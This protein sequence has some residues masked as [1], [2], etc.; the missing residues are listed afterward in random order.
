MNLLKK[1]FTRKEEPPIRFIEGTRTEHVMTCVNILTGYVHYVPSYFREG[2]MRR[3]MACEEVG[4][5]F[6]I[7]WVANHLRNYIEGCPIYKPQNFNAEIHGKCPEFI[8]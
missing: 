1:L 6:E 7:V 3:M 4:P 5:T 2:M 8:N